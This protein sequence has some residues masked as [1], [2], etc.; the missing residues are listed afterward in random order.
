VYLLRHAPC[1]QVQLSLPD[2]YLFG[3]FLWQGGPRA[4]LFAGFSAMFVVNEG[5]KI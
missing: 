4:R 1:A 2:V 3:V 5:K